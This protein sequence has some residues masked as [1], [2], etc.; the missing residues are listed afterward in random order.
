LVRDKNKEIK[1]FLEFNK[2]VD[3]SCPNLWN[4]MK[5]VLRGKKSD[6]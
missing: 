1:G 4:I 6:H 3:T 2:N 5:E